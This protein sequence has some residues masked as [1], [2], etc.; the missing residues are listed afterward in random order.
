MPLSVLLP[1]VVL[2]ISGIAL[3][4]HLLG[5]SG[6]LRLDREAAIAGWQREMGH[7]KVQQ[8]LLAPSGHAALVQSDTGAGLVW[9]LGRDTVARTLGPGSLTRAK[10]RL[11]VSFSDYGSNDV[12]LDLPP[13]TQKLWIETVEKGLGK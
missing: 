5:K 6:R 11:R 8:V 12:I 3:L 10:G 7:T 4:L 2:G 1:M 9:V 13:D